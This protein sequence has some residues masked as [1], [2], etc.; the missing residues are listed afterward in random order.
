MALAFIQESLPLRDPQDGWSANYG[1]WIRVAMLTFAMTCSS[2][3]PASYFIDG[4]DLSVRQLLAVST[5]VSVLLVGSS[6]AVSAYLRWPIPFSMLTMSP[7]F[8]VV[9]FSLVMGADTVC[10]AKLQGKQLQMVVKLLSILN[11]MI[12]LYCSCLPSRGQYSFLLVNSVAG[13]L[14]AGPPGE[15]LS[16]A[17]H[18]RQFSCPPTSRLACS[19]SQDRDDGE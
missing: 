17:D 15:R 1:H 14:L 9:S 5:C 11:L 8:I 6:L 16:L 3:A 18:A 2:T 13:V 19:Q 7:I 10:R 12:L 4:M